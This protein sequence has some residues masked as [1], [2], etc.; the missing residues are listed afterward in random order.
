MTVAIFHPAFHTIGGAEILVAYYARALEKAG[1]EMRVVTLA[2][3]AERWKPWLDGISVRVVPKAPWTDVFASRVTQLERIARRAESCFADCNAVLA[4]NFPTN[5]LVGASSIKAKR[6]WYSTE[7][8]RY[9]HM[10]ATN[11]RLYGRVKSHPGGVTDAERDFA[12]SVA[13]YERSIARRSTRARQIAFDVENTNKLDTIIAISEFG[14][15]NVRRVY[16]RTAENV[17]APIVRFPAERAGRRSGL[18][19]DGLKI[20]THSRLEI[21][22]N[23]DGVIRGFARLLAKVPGSELHVLGEGTHRKNLEALV[24][25]L[26]IGSAVRF[27]GYVPEKDLE[28]VYDLC[29]VFALTTLDEP[30]GMVYPEA[31]ARGLLLVGPDHGGPFEILDGGKLGWVCDPFEPEA[32]EEAFLRIWALSDAEVDARRA[33]ADRACRSRYSEETIGPKLYRALTS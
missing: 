3:D 22:K 19:R 27:H 31:A 5:I 9:W 17:I 33:E 20:L 2:I 16:G 29:D 8:S 14:R 24:R 4:F 26:G 10:I 23:V 30:F 6:A 32:L 21:P 12:P 7:P 13:R 28:R 18:R 25:T 15:D 1:L 11:P